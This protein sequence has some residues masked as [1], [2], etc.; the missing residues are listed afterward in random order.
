MQVQG[1]VL[2]RSLCTQHSA[3]KSYSR[4][5]ESED[6]RCECMKWITTDTYVSTMFQRYKRPQ[7]TFFNKRKH[8]W[9]VRNTSISRN[10]RMVV[11][12]NNVVGIRP[13]SSD[14]KTEQEIALVQSGVQYT[15][16]YTVVCNRIS[17]SPAK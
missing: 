7:T 16:T 11:Y 3:L 1:P 9:Y 4:K 12:V 14:W 15:R 10:I 2:R 6:L 8:K 5:C 17:T 13:K